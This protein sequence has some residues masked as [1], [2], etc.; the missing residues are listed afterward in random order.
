[1]KR[2]ASYD[3]ASVFS[4]DDDTVPYIYGKQF[5]EREDLVSNEVEQEEEEEE[6]EEDEEEDDELDEDDEGLLFE[7]Q[8]IIPHFGAQITY[9]AIIMTCFRVQHSYS[10]SRTTP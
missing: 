1:M 8:N 10:N 5:D 9:V 2:A 4:T 3:T 6:E 7:T